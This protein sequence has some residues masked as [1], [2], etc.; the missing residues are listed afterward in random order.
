MCPDKFTLLDCTNTKTRFF[1]TVCT[2][3]KTI[4]FHITDAHSFDTD[5]QTWCFQPL[6]LTL[7]VIFRSII[8]K[9][10]KKIDLTRKV[11][12]SHTKIDLKKICIIVELGM[13]MIWSLGVLSSIY[14]FG[15]SVCLFVCLFVSNKHQN[16]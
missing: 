8:S 5:T 12:K 7:S 3:S 6:A 13:K 2:N 15:L 16:D 1:C 9:L 14:K 11:R 10:R 4:R